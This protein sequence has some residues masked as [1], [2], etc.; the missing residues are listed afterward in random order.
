MTKKHNME[1]KSGINIEICEA[2]LM[3][4]VVEATTVADFVAAVVVV[5]ANVVVV[6]IKTQLIGP[7][8][9]EYVLFGYCA[10]ANLVKFE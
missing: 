6:V 1:T 10:E 4:F 7:I 3:L 2:A 5:G 9:C 8:E